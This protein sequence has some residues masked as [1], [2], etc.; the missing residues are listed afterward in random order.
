MK[1]MIE[2]MIIIDNYVN[3]LNENISKPIGNIDSQSLLLECGFYNDMILN[4]NTFTD[5]IKELFKR[6]KEIMKQLGRKIV[7]AGKNMI[8]K[9]K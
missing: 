8:N 6:F 4:E 1:G 2:I 9:V 5:K 7:T 3:Q